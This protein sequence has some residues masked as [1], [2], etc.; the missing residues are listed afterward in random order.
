M[1]HTCWCIVFECFEFK[2]V[3]EFIWLV[4]FKNTKPF[5]FIVF[6]FPPFWPVFVLSPVA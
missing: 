5:S 3:F 1:L 6:P 4:A 2:F